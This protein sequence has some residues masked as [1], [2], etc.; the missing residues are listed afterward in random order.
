[1]KLLV[2]GGAGYIGTPLCTRL[3]E[4][5]QVVCWDPGFFGYHF[6]KDAE[7]IRV[8]PRRVQE[9]TLA[10]L[11][12]HAPDW[13][14]HLSGLSNDPMADFAP[15]MNWV[16][17][18]DATCHVGEL[19]RALSIPMLFASSA[20]VYG[21][22]PD[23][24]LDEDAPVA[25]IG[26]YSESKAAAEHWLRE[27]H[28]HV[29]IF[30]QATV[31]GVSP[32]MRFDLLTNGM[33]RAAWAKNAL[34]VLYGGRETRAQVHVLD[35]VAAYQ[36][37]LSRPEF[38]AGTYNVASRNDRVMELAETV[39][40]HLKRSG[41]NVTL[42]VSDEPRKHR[43]YALSSKKLES[44]SGWAPHMTALDTVDELLRLL[45]TLEQ[46]FDPRYENIRWMKLLHE[47]QGVLSRIGSIDVAAKRVV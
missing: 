46:P 20:S 11:R 16:E 17:N 32:R 44:L 3:A 4:Q 5:H 33:T 13:V 41:R 14:L 2:T 30:R 18:A 45:D 10:D 19:T 29:V 26:N 34:T 23:A 7:R 21:F 47:A 1:M 24:L 42:D 28:G 40:D 38:P 35:L 43:S 15:K 6:G 36:A 27:H 39:R 22:Q 9:L 25:P 8:V 37:V 31:M 12:E